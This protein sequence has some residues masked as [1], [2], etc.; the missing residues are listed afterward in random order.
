MYIFI[1]QHHFNRGRVSAPPLIIMSN[2]HTIAR[3][4]FSALIAILGLSMSMMT[5]A[6]SSEGSS[7]SST[8]SPSSSSISSEPAASSQSSTQGFGTI[9]IEQKNSSDQQI[10][11]EWTLL[12]PNQEEQKSTQQSVVLANI[13]TGSYTLFIAPPEGYR[14]SIRTYHGS[15]QM[16]YVQRPQI[17]IKLQ[18]G[19]NIRVAI[20]YSLTRTGVISVQSDPSGLDFTLKGPNNLLKKGKTPMSYENSPEGPYSLQFGTLEGCNTPA[21]LSQELVTD[22]RVTFDVKLACKAADKLRERQNSKGEEYVVIS[23]EGIDVQLRDVP[24]NSWFSTYVFEA[25]RRGI[26]SGYKDEAG[27]PSGTFGPANSVTVAELAKI[28]HRLAGA[29]EQSFSG[30]NPE[31]ILATGQWF[32]PFIAS[33][34]NRGW[35]LYKDATIDPLRSVTR[36]E[37]MVTLLQVMD[38]PLK[39]QKGDVFTDVTVRTRYAS[40]IET[41]AHDNIIE[42]LKD[43]KGL[44]LNTFN[45]EGAINRAELAKIINKIFEVY[46]GKNSRT[47]SSS[48]SN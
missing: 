33:A 28:A 42:G 13:P 35:T 18:A 46:F 2:R 11:G 17:T 25:A 34:E 37:V 31:N 36:A 14:T 27:K 30:K 39:W 1:V 32:S 16:D 3:L 8:P 4:S 48:R 6:Q 40:A 47:Q 43:E 20:N 10:F 24:Q 5:F 19:D 45:P 12:I 41:A 22:S 23:V 44:S 21:Q 7:S 26:L 9:T 29:G 38:V 15:E